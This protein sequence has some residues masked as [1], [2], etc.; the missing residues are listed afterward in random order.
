MTSPIGF[1]D[2]LSGA[3]AIT[4]LLSAATSDHFRMRWCNSDWI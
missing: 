2:S 1:V 4:T 3:L